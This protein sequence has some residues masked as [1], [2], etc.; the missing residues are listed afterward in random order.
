MQIDFI[1]ETREGQFPFHLDLENLP[2]AI[3]N[4]FVELKEFVIIGKNE[5]QQK[6]SADAN[7][8]RCI[9]V[10]KGKPYLCEDC[11]IHKHGTA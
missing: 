10:A 4:K 3:G 11:P 7:K 6:D 8:E 5:T 1:V 9:C 2:T